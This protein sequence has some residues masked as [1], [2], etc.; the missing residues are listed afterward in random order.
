MRI[1]EIYCKCG[2]GKRIGHQKAKKGR[3]FLNKIHANRYNGT[4]RIGKKYNI[5]L[6]KEGDEK[7]GKNFYKKYCKNFDSDKLTC[8]NCMDLAVF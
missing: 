7:M 4:K 1:K 3:I 6:K 2:C 8:L 5:I